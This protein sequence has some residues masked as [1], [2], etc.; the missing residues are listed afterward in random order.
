[1]RG[2]IHCYSRREFAPGPGSS[3]SCDNPWNARRKRAKLGIAAPLGSGGGDDSLRASQHRAP[4]PELAGL[5]ASLPHAVLS[6]CQ[7][8]GTCRSGPGQAWAELK[9]HA[10]VRLAET[11]ELCEFRQGGVVFTGS[12]IA[13][14]E[15][16]WGAAVCAHA[17]P[18]SITRSWRPSNALRTPSTDTCNLQAAAARVPP[19]E[20]G[21]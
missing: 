7:M 19:V 18:N 12:T 16:R 13:G 15:V 20:V 9:A 11:S 14:Q 5:Q 17:L 3:Y 8:H 1:M 4:P 10:G 6:M 21:G 2:S